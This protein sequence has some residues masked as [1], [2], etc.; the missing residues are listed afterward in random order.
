MDQQI[1]YYTD[2]DV[3]RDP[4]FVATCIGAAGLMIMYFKQWE[5]AARRKR[6]SDYIAPHPR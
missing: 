6:G 1:N 3:E 4:G 5:K 2:R